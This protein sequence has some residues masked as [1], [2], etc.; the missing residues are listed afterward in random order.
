MIKEMKYIPVTKDSF[1]FATATVA[2]GF[3]DIG[4]VEDEYFMSGTANV[5]TEN[6]KAEP[7]VIYADAPYTTRLLIRRPEDVSRFSGNVVIEVLNATAMVDIDRMWMNSW[8]YFTRNGDIY[9]GISSKG[10]VVDSMKKFNPERYADINWANPTPDREY[11]EKVKNTGF[12]FL[13]Q[14]ESGLFWD[15]QVELAKLLRTDD[16]LN[17]IREY[18]DRYLYLTG[19][20]Q[21]GSYLARILHSFD[22]EEKPLFDGYLSAGSGAGNAPINSYETTDF[23]FGKPGVSSGSMIGGRQP[24]I[25]I[26]TESENRVTNWYGDFD[27]PNYK[28]RTYQIPGSSHDTKYDLIEYYQMMGET[29]FSD[30]QPFEGVDGDPL[31]YPYE[32]IFSAAFYHLYRWAREGV[33]APHAPKIETYIAKDGEGTDPFGSLIE[34]CTDA[35]GNAKGGIRTP[36]IDYPTG[37]YKGTCT[38]ADGSSGIFGT[39]NPFSPAMLKELYGSLENYRNLVEKGADEMMAL[40]FLLEGDRKVFLERIMA[41]AKERGLN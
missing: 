32:P 2:C 1:P 34:N 14:Y 23:F 9:I 40:G 37:R 30:G 6:M 5:Y 33:P 26:N 28:F 4:Y 17:P 31:D 41:S 11:P 21:S 29:A 24:F 18:K 39:V 22:T 8:P 20:S 36:A 7:S 15:M 10:H 16:E 35:F 27:E 3:K 12:Q 25:S 19:W 38:K 13:P